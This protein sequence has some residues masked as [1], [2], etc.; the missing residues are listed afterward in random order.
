VRLSMVSRLRQ[1]KVTQFAQI[2][3]V[4]LCLSPIVR[5]SQAFRISYESGSEDLWRRHLC[6]SGKFLIV[7]NVEPVI[8]VIIPTFRRPK[9]LRRAIL[10]VLSQTFTA[11]QVCVHNY[12]LNDDTKTVISKLAKTDSRIR[13]Y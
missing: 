8:T 5:I 12:A 2:V 9:L 11:F 13:Y 1:K 7:T 4:D 6:S 3:I 10:S